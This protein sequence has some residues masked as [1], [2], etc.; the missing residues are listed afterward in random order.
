MRT[1]ETPVHPGKP[2][3][4]GEFT[5]LVRNSEDSRVF[6]HLA[7]TV[8]GFLELTGSQI[9]KE[10]SR[11]SHYTCHVLNQTRRN[12]KRTLE[13]EKKQ[14][15]KEEEKSESTTLKGTTD[16]PENMLSNEEVFRRS[17]FLTFF[18]GYFFRFPLIH[19]CSFFHLYQ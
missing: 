8:P 14:E 19:L 7:Q 3:S 17:K 6:K 9:K 15:E 12:I 18:I 4:K 11:F 5:V 10:H 13:K 2:N 1:E 16:N